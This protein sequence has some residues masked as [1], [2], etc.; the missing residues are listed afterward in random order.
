LL[1]SIDKDGTFSGP[2]FDLINHIRSTTRISLLVNGGVASYEDVIECAKLGVDGVVMG[3]AL[4]F[5]KLNISELKLK[6]L[7]NNIEVRI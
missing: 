1:T 7:E 4:H 3:S 2:D 5:N 6:L